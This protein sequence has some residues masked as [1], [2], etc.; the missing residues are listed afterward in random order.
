M[1]IIRVKDWYKFFK[2]F[3]SINII[4]YICALKAWFLNDKLHRIDGPA[5]KYFNGTKFWYLNNK[6]H[7]VDGPAIEWANGD[8][9][10][11][12]NDKRHRIDGPAIEWVSGYKEYWI[13]GERVSKEAQEVLYGFYKLKGIKK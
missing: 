9:H 2:N 11:Y 6:R 7:R 3:I 13:N 12:L 1:K 8:K 5:I 4:G 10:W